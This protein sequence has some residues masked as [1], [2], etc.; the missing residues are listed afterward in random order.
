M[1]NAEHDVVVEGQIVLDE[2]TVGLW[3]VAPGPGQDWLASLREIEPDRTYELLYRFKYFQGDYNPFNDEDEV[4][5]YGG[6]IKGTKNFVIAGV[7]HAAKTLERGGDRLCEIL[8]DGDIK[9]LVRKLQE[10]PGIYCRMVGPSG[11]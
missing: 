7:R 5:W 10:T 1:T 6:T 8:N 2:K 4:N 3:M 9:K 11:D